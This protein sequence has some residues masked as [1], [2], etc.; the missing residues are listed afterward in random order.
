MKL[1]IYY[2]ALRDAVIH[3]LL[4]SLFREEVLNLSRRHES[5]THGD[6]LNYKTMYDELRVDREREKATVSANI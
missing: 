3:Q 4:L 2:F 5:P 1:N 6:S